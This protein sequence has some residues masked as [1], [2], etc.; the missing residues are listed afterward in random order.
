MNF[1]VIARPSSC[2]CWVLSGV[3]SLKLL[4]WGAIWGTIPQVV[5][6]ECYLESYPS[7]CYCGVL[8]GVL[9]VQLL[10][11]GAISSRISQVV[12]VG[13]YL[14]YSNNFFCNGKIKPVD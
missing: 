14:N 3:L 2:Y 8:S 10:L 13:C 5:I 4:L 7:S 12:I 11:R 6:A 9:S 1:R